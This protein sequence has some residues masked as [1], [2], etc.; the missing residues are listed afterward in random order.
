MPKKKFKYRPIMQLPHCCVSATLQ[1]ILYRRGLDILT[2]EE[3]G[4]NLGLRMPMRM[5]EL[6]SDERIEWLPDD[7]KENFGTQIRK[8]GC[9]I[10]YFFKRKGIPLRI[11]KLRKMKSVDNIEN[12]LQENMNDNNDIISSY[13][14]WLKSKGKYKYVG[15]FA[16]VEK[17][18]F[19]N[20]KV[21]LCD[22][23]IP[24]WKEIGFGDLVY[25][26]SMEIDGR[27]RGFYKVVRNKK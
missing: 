8:K 24:F 20:K 25:Q 19:K 10:N 21:L 7:S 27:V 26:M 12:F 22:P 9:G 13:N 3:I 4:A 1:M 17:V 6:F 2:Q 11:S 16:L 15:H 23:E 5:R 18:D 14:A